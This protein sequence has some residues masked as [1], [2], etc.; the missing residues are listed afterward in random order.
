MSNRAFLF[1]FGENRSAYNEDLPFGRLLNDA[2]VLPIF[3]GSN[4]G[5]RRRALQEL[6]MGD[7]YQPWISSFGAE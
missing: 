1:L 4:V 2:L 6:F 3:D 7:G 5:V